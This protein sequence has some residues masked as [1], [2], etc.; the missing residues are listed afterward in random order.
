MILN[1]MTSLKLCFS[2]ASTCLNFLRW[3]S[4][5]TICPPAHTVP[6]RRRQ[7][8]HPHTAPPVHR[9]TCPNTPDD[10][11]ANPPIYR[12]LTI[13]PAR[14]HPKCSHKS[15]SLQLDDVSVY[16]LCL[17][18]RISFSTENRCNADHNQ[19][20]KEAVPYLISS[21]IWRTQATENLYSFD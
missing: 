16:C 7:H 15:T 10:L 2:I 5:W 3:D 17:A 21:S 19:S 14:Q 18:R 6:A 20:A 9:F 4:W 1:W 13:F 8:A 12:P 11:S